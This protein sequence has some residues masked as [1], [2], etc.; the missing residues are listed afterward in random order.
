ML[1]KKKE[2]KMRRRV[3][4]IE[5]AQ[6]KIRR[7]ERSEVFI[8]MIGGLIWFGILIFMWIMATGEEKE[9]ENE[10]VKDTD[11]NLDIVNMESYE[12]DDEEEED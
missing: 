3:K 4:A 11:K 6:R 1:D 10:E 7:K 9:E 2:K 5:K 8:S 12:D